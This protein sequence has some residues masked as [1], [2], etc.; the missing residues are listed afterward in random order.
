M[1]ESGLTLICSWRNMMYSI[2]SWRTEAVSVCRRHQKITIKIIYFQELINR[3]IDRT[4]LYIQ[5]VELE[6]CQKVKLVVEARW[7][8]LR[9]SLYEPYYPKI[10]Y[11]RKLE[12]IRLNI[13]ASSILKNKRSI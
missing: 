13:I 11:G 3:E 6:P 12:T 8:Y 7:F 2:A 4:R 5:Y 9:V 10:V 1:W